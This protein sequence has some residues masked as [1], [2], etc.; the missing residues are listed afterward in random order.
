VRALEPK[1]LATPVEFSFT[2]YN[3][4]LNGALV[5]L[6]SRTGSGQALVK[7]HQPAMLFLKELHR[8]CGRGRR[9]VQVREGADQR[10]LGPPT[11]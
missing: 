5:A 3:E 1:F 10:W 2:A 7:Y 4:Q 9:A 6:G 8:R 11:K